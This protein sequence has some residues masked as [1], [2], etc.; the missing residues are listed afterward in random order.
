MTIRERTSLAFPSMTYQ[1]IL[2]GKPDNYVKM[3]LAKVHTYRYV[4]GD[5]WVD[6]YRGNKVGWTR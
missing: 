5:D 1:R 3:N 6:H 2:Q 4:L